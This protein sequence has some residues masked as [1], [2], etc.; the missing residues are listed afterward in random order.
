MKILILLFT[1]FTL[2]TFAQSEVRYVSRYTPTSSK[3]NTNDLNHTF[4]YS[5]A[6]KGLKVCFGL[7]EDFKFE[8]SSL[9]FGSEAPIA[10][11]DNFT[12]GTFGGIQVSNNSDHNVSVYIGPQI[13]YTVSKIVDIYSDVRWSYTSQDPMTSMGLGINFKL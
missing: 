4:Q 12:F 13:T 10:A 8:N 3:P 7:I 5:Y 11:K 2:N 6:L 1:L 9:Y